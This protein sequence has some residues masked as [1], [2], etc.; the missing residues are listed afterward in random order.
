MRGGFLLADDCVSEGTY[1]RDSPPAFTRGIQDV[2]S[3]VFPERAF[4]VIPDDHPVYH[5]IYDFPDGLPRMTSNGR[6]KGLGLFD[7][8]RLMVLLSPNDICCGWQFSWGRLTTNAYQ[9]GINIFVYALT[10]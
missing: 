7:D 8:E 1:S 3:R 10:H 4:E 5:C 9:I 6:W 2:M